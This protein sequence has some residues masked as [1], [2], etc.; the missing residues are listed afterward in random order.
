MAFSNARKQCKALAHSVSN[1]SLSSSSSTASLTAKVT[2][3]N[4]DEE[5]QI[6]DK[7]DMDYVDSLSPTSSN[8]AHTKPSKH[9]RGDSDGGVITLD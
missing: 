1:S 9:A 3:T 6:D 7:M 2:P 8:S 5:E 4:G